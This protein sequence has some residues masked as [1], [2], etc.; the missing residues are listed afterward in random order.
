MRSYEKGPPA[1]GEAEG[2]AIT[3]MGARKPLSLLRRTHV[4]AV[5]GALH[6]LD[7]AVSEGEQRVVLATTDVLARHDVRATLTND[8]LTGL[9]GLAAEDLRAEALSRGVTTVTGASLV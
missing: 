3:Q 6:E 9:D 2:P 5:L 4:H 7:G 1:S 8:N